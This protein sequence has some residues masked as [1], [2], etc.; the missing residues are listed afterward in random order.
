LASVR[1]AVLAVMRGLG[2]HCRRRG[3]GGRRA[4]AGSSAATRHG[5]RSRGKQGHEGRDRA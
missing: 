2:R 1:V 3:R 4:V 5:E